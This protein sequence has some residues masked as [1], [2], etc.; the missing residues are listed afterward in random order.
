[1]EWSAEAKWRP[2]CS[3]RCQLIDLGAWMT[4]KHA[5][6][7]EELNPDGVGVPPDDPGADDPP[8]H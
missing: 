1:V 5:I 2:F 6:P 7:G 3:E 4:E 8:R